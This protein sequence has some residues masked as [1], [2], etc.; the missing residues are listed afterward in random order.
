MVRVVTLGA[1]TD[2]ERVRYLNPAQ[3]M[4]VAE[5]GPG[6]C[7]VRMVGQTPEEGSVKV[8]GPAAELAKA[9]ATSEPSAAEEVA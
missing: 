6:F 2:T 4:W 3:V 9:L 8:L 1:T 7:Y 5:G